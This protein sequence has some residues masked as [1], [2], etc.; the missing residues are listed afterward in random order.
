MMR[1]VGR[2]V[3]TLSLFVLIFA[4]CA[5]SEAETSTTSGEGA[6]ASTSGSG[7]EASITIEGFAFS[8]ATT[9]DAGTTVVA[10]NQDGVTHT[11]T[12]ADEVWNSGG[13][14]SG[15]SFEFTFTDPGEYDYFCSIHPQMTG[16]LIVEG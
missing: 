12:S 1:M 2:S 13:L 5:G 10:T 11:W 8:G 6:P 9:V 4:A 14:A 3:L 15:D 16:T 7:A